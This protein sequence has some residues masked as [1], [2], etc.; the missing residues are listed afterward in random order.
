[1]AAGARDI[2]DLPK[3]D[4]NYTALTPLL[5][6]DRAALIHPSRLSVI[7]GSRR[8]TWLQTYQRCRRLASVLSNR[9]IGAGDT[10]L[11]VY[12]SLSLS[13]SPLVNYYCES[14]SFDWSCYDD[15]YRCWK[16]I[17]V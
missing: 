5:F 10:V 9:S 17:A 13:L 2:D 14:N 16:V 15:C 8:Y 1:M 7:H 3:N 11:I 4:A 6:L 12:L